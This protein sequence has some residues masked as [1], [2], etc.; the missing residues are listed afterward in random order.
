MT[1]TSLN[2]HGWTWMSVNYCNRFVMTWIYLFLYSSSQITN[3]TR[4]VGAG[5]SFSSMYGQTYISLPCQPLEGITHSNRVLG[6]SYSVPAPILMTAQFEPHV[7]AWGYVLPLSIS[8]LFALASAGMLWS[9]DVFS[10]ATIERFLHLPCTEDEAA[11]SVMTT[12]ASCLPSLQVADGTLKSLLGRWH[13]EN[14]SATTS[15]Y[16]FSWLYW[17]ITRNS[18]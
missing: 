12:I 18:T 9:T 8:S 6:M 5:P 2:Y 15:N 16:A 17:S 4:R 13:A 3:E 10:D 11:L 1:R 7:M 14:R